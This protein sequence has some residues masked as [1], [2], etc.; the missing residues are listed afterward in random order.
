MKFNSNVLLVGV[1]ISLIAWFPFPVAL[2]TFTRITISLCSAYAAYCFYKEG[3]NIWIILA[4]TTILYNPILPVYLYDRDLWQVIN[5]L[6]ALMFIYSYSLRPDRNLYLFFYFGKVI[7]IGGL[8]FWM[9]VTYIVYD[10]FFNERTFI[11]EPIHG[12]A[13]IALIALFILPFGLSKVWNY[14]FLKDSSFW[15]FSLKEKDK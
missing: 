3:H 5:I 4:L 12:V 1:V 15:I 9:V 2:Y 8:L 7:F 6:T 10:A 14:F 11:K 13:L